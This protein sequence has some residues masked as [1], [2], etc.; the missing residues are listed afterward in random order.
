MTVFQ[1]LAVWLKDILD[2]I[3]AGAY[4]VDLEYLAPVPERGIEGAALMSNPHDTVRTLI[5]GLNRQYTKYK[6]LNI[7]RDIQK[8]SERIS[9]E[10]FF[11]RLQNEI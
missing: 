9:N 11:D 1:E 7:R 2:G 3:E 5:G 10:A 6:T 4:Y 8:S